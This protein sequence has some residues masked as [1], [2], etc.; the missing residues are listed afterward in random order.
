MNDQFGFFSHFNKTKTNSKYSD[1]KLNL[2]HLIA[3][4][5][6]ILNFVYILEPPTSRIPRVPIIRKPNPVLMTDDEDSDE[7]IIPESGNLKNN[8]F[9]TTS[10]D[11]TYCSEI[12]N[13]DMEVSKQT[14]K[15]IFD[16]DE[17]IEGVKKKS[18]SVS[19]HTQ[20]DTVVGSFS[21][22][23]ERL[24][25][26]ISGLQ[27]KSAKKQSKS[28]QRSD[29][30]DTIYD[31]FDSDE[32]YDDP[33]PTQKKLN[34]TSCPPDNSSF[35]RETIV[36]SFNSDE[37]NEE[38]EENKDNFVKPTNLPKYIP[39]TIPKN[40][41]ETIDNPF[42]YSESVVNSTKK[43]IH[44]VL[45]EID[46]TTDKFSG[47]ELNENEGDNEESD[48][49]DIECITVLDS[50]E[51]AEGSLLNDNDEPPRYGPKDSFIN[52]SS[53]AVSEPTNSRE[54]DNT[55]NRFFNNPPSLDSNE[56]VTHAIIHKHFKK[57]EPEEKITTIP[58]TTV[59]RFQTKEDEIEINDS[60]ELEATIR[61]ED[62][63]VDATIM[64]D[65][66]DG[67]D[68]LGS[69]LSYKSSSSE[70]ETQETEKSLARTTSHVTQDPESQGDNFEI[71]NFHLKINLNVE[72][73]VE[74]AT[75]SSS[76]EEVVKS[77]VKKPST[78]L[79]NFKVNSA[80]NSPRT[81]A[82]TPVSKPTQKTSNQ[83]SSANKNILN[84]SVLRGEVPAINRA[85]T[86]IQTSK[87][88]D[89]FLTPTR[90]NQE[91]SVIDDDLQKILNDL[92]GESWKTPQLLKSCQKTKN[93][94]SLRKSIAANNFENCKY[95]A[96]V[97]K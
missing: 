37:D 94:E 47:I 12:E 77:P 3:K 35:M 32:S 9:N 60:F 15:A 24:S 73:T 91:P 81:P 1:L 42:E 96:T 86:T 18:S 13:K 40:L 49:S 58:E 89:N 17:L 80:K 39:P 83:K 2:K 95:F 74:D 75:D 67:Q 54:T 28:S 10:T 36:G 46:S 26:Q 61:S 63:I 7:N 22:D 69:E 33:K 44:E 70:K 23:E 97:V 85:S 56:V 16:T 55:L 64:T 84:H 21:S 20:A 8:I 65:E 92:Y 82:N 11:N 79:I 5:H 29:L 78:P 66:N 76:D 90:T 41:R 43:S 50:D 59:D 25:T 72:F 27:L 45:N 31:P 51:E 71:G 62:E 4:Y 88:A 68:I 19:R 53:V 52:C 14:S 34:K 38:E 6:E 30:K 48:D 87:A 93:V 57:P